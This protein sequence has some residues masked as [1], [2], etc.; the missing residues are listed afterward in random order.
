MIFTNPAILIWLIIDEIFDKY[1]QWTNR[2]GMMWCWVSST[3]CLSWCVFLAPLKFESY[4]KVHVQKSMNEMNS[5]LTKLGTLFTY[6]VPWASLKQLF[7]FG[8]T[9][10]LGVAF[11]GSWCFQVRISYYWMSAKH[12]SLKVWVPHR[13]LCFEVVLI[14]CHET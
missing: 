4:P 1:K 7:W 10:N 11:I 9:S 3:T 8:N 12:T 2:L 5:I 6:Y 13:T 14:C